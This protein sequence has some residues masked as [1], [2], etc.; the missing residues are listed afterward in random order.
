MTDVGDYAN[1]LLAL[2]GAHD[3]VFVS[4]I[5]G[6][7]ESPVVAPSTINNGG[8][9]VID[10]VRLEPSCSSATGDAAPPIRLVSFAQRFENQAQHSICDPALGDAMSTLGQAVADRLQ[11]R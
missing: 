10:V 5:A 6:A 2:K 1:T 8:Q 3:R 4:V 7:Y 9:G 11:E